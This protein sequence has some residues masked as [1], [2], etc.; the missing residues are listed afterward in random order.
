MNPESRIENIAIYAKDK[1]DLALKENLQEKE[2]L[3][4][5]W[6]HTLR[7]AQY[8][9]RLAKIEGAN[10]EQVIA[11]CLLHD[12]AKLSD[13]CHTVEHGRVGERMVREFLKKLGYTKVER[14]N[15]RYAIA[16]HVD[17]EAGFKHPHILEAKVLSDADKLDRFSTYRTALELGDLVKEEYGDFIAAVESRVKYLRSVSELDFMQT[18]SGKKAFEKQIS[19]QIDYLER[20]LAD[21]EITTLPE[22]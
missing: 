20:L 7:V 6:L 8:G 5:R 10:V 22:L 12:I 18:K 2:S 13:E 1:N 16:S 17:G 15:I 4:Y 11:S 21:Y 14:K 3:T 19:V 9:K